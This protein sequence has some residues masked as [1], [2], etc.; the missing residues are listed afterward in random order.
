[1]EDG[2]P[3]RWPEDPVAWLDPP[4]LLAAWVSGHDEIVS[5]HVALVGAV[6]DRLLA[7]A[8][9]RRLD[10]LASVSRLFVRPS[11]RGGGLAKALLTAAGAFA[12]EQGLG[13]VLEVVADAVAAITLYE[14]L[15]WQLIDRRPASWTTDDGQHPHVRVYLRS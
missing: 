6:D 2:Y 10:Q 13:L 4:A 11:A 5:G 8:T 9:G 7:R 3:K 14:R 15:G 1:M 12:A